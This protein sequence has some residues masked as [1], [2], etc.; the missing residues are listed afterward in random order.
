VNRHNKFDQV[1]RKEE[2]T[3]TGPNCQIY[4]KG[5]FLAAMLDWCG[6]IKTKVKVPLTATSPGVY[7]SAELY[8]AFEFTEANQKPSST[9]VDAPSARSWRACSNERAKRNRTCLKF[10]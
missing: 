10:G 1:T 4:G 5:S 8:H 9:D 2:L 6:I 3:M 7:T